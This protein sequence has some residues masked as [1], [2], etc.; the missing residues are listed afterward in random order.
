MNSIIFAAGLDVYQFWSENVEII[1]SDFIPGG[2]GKRWAVENCGAVK[3]GIELTK[4]TNFSQ[5][6]DK[7]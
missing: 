4:I 6:S 5:Y 3:L 2:W 1:E 7:Y